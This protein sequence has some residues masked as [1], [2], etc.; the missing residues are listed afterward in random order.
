MNERIRQI[1][2]R[3]LLA[4]MLCATALAGCA[5]G[6]P[7]LE[8]L[9]RKIEVERFMGDWYVV[10]FIPID[11]PFFSEADAH[12]AVESYALDEEGKIDVTYTFRDG[13]FDA[14]PTVMTQRGRVYDAD[15]GTEWRVQPF[16]PFW[17]AYLIAWLDEDYGRAIVGVPSRKYVWVLSRSADLDEAELVALTERVGALGYD[18]TELRRVPHRQAADAGA[19]K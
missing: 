5:S 14:E 17:S 9:D 6:P 15:R 13:S 12:D 7:P 4:I 16:W 19:Q 10:A 11:L 8:A 1:G 2:R 3:G 18:P